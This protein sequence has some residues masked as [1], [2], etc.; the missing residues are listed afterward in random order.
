[1]RLSNVAGQFLSRVTLVE[2]SGKDTVQDYFDG[3]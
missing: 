3:T 2:N 1:M